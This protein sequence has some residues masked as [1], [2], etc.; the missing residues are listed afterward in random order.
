MRGSAVSNDL[1]VAGTPPQPDRHGDAEATPSDDDDSGGPHNRGTFSFGLGIQIGKNQLAIVPS[2]GYGILSFVSLGV[3][4]LYSRYSDHENKEIRKGGDFETLL[5]VPWR[6]L[7]APF[8]GAGIGYQ[9]WK[10]T[11]EVWED[12]GRSPIG[13]T[14][15]GLR[16][17]LGSYAVLQLRRTWSQYISRPPN[18]FP[19]DSD[20][21]AKRF[22]ETSI[23][24]LIV[25]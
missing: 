8:V 3:S 15:V 7:V 25:F 13:R 20:R 22:T 21:E 1:P 23:G 19:P 24:F 4:G 5:H 9:T 17:R 16:F 2:V 12:K 18:R 11:T 10:R 6:F 14:I